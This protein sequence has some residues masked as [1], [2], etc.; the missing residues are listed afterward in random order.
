[1]LFAYCWQFIFSI[2]AIYFNRCLEICWRFKWFQCTSSANCDYYL[3]ERIKS[4]TLLHHE[5]TSLMHAHLVFEQGPITVSYKFDN[6][7]IVKWL[8]C[9]TSYF[10]IKKC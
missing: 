2:D 1:M 4:V 8:Q 7:V 3:I 10:Y 5:E 6:G 9:D